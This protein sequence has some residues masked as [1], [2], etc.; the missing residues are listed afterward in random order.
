M[1]AS[2]CGA[3]AKKVFA[4]PVFF[5]FVPTGWFEL[6]LLFGGFPVQQRI[7]PPNRC[8]FLELGFRMGV[9]CPQRSK[10]RDPWGKETPQKVIGSRVSLFL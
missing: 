10:G 3:A 8:F 9:L 4:V 2:Q 6:P 7:K 5:V 1:H